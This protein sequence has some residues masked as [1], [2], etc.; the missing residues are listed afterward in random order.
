MLELFT[1]PESWAAIAA[2]TLL[3]IVLGIDNIVFIAIVTEKLPPNLRSIARKV[4]LS[5]ALIMRLL[6]LFTLSWII[7]LEKP[8]FE[9][10]GLEFSGRSLIMLIGGLFLIVKATME[11]YKKTELLEKEAHPAAGATTFGLV[12][13][14]IVFLDMIFS[15]ESIITAVGMVNEIPLMVT[16]IVI[17]II[18]MI[19]FTD[20]F[21]EYI[22]KH[23][24][25]K[26]LALSFLLLIGVLLV[27]DGTGYHLPRG[28]I[29]FA[30]GFSLMIE[31]FNMRYRKKLA[32]REKRA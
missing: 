16:A 17:S 20:P 18:V 10:A 5:L 9:L 27:A 1:R 28:Y 24:S 7:R 25:L 6:L 8:L 19:I 32:M 14:Q 4:G 13:V 29:Y 26:I 23:S 22:D 30:M 12:L 21:S 11:I 15:L 31:F 3:E 2:L